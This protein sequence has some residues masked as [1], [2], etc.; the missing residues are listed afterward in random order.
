[1][2]QFDFTATTTIV[3]IPETATRRVV[4]YKESPFDP[5]FVGGITPDGKGYMVPGD[6]GNPEWRKALAAELNRAQLHYNEA[7]RKDGDQPLS[8]RQNVLKGKGVIVSIV[9]KT[10]KARKSNGTP[11]ESDK[12]GAPNV[13]KSKT[14]SKTEQPAA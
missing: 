5:Y 7:V 10:T 13:R 6:T 12:S 3:E 11:T 1:M 14:E 2:A 8:Y 4:E 9:P